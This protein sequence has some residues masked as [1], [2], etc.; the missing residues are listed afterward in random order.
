ME[1]KIDDWVG[2]CVAENK[3]AIAAHSISL[4]YGRDEN[5]SVDHLHA[6]WLTYSDVQKYFKRLRKAKYKFR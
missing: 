5:D 1:T 6:A 3:T 2:R 4:T